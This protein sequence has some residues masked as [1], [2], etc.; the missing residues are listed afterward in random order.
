MKRIVKFPKK[1]KA[2]KGKNNPMFGKRL[3]KEHRAKISFS[4]L[5]EKSPFWKGDSAGIKPKHAWIKRMRGT[6]SYCEHCKRTDKKQYDWANVDHKYKRVL[7]DWLRLCTT[8]H[9]KYDIDFNKYK[10]K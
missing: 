2:K 9:R 1:S 3:S 10:Q 4:L 6:P 8:C 7:S 5:G